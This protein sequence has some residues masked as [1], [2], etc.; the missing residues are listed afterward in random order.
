M[1]RMTAMFIAGLALW[2]VLLHWPGREVQAQKAA[3]GTIADFAPGGTATKLAS[4]G[5][6]RWVKVCVP[7]ANSGIARVG[8]S[9]VSATQ[10]ASV[11]AAAT[12]GCMTLD[13]IPAAPGGAPTNVLYQLS[14]IYAFA[15]STDKVQVTYGN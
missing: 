6:A 1:N 10:G 8:D 12:Q 11:A 15:S 4:S 7:A 3:L 14:T 13:P 5:S 9:N 2:A